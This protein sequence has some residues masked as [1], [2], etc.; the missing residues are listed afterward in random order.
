[1]CVSIKRITIQLWL[2]IFVTVYPQEEVTRTHHWR[3]PFPYGMDITITTATVNSVF[4]PLWPVWPPSDLL[5]HEALQPSVTL[6]HCQPNISKN[7][8]QQVTNMQFGLLMQ[9]LW[10]HGNRR[11]LN[12]HSAV[13]PSDWGGERAVGDPVVTHRER[14]RGFIERMKPFNR[15]TAVGIVLPVIELRHN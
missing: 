6:P 8:L 15:P 5:L 4:I 9:L 11:Q 12:S 7:K 14:N 13:P 10:L 3:W 1:M 2:I